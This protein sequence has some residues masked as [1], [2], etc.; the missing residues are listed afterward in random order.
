VSASNF[1]DLDE[2]V[3][4]GR[5]VNTYA[6]LDPRELMYYFEN[7]YNFPRKRLITDVRIRHP[8]F[9]RDQES[10]QNAVQSVLDERRW[11]DN[12][13]SLATD[14]AGGILD[15]G[16]QRDEEREI[17]GSDASCDGSLPPPATYRQPHTEYSPQ[18]DDGSSLEDSGYGH[19][20][21][22]WIDPYG[23]GRI[24]R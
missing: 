2:A 4:R 6:K 19:P 11:L 14:S 12:M 22:R 15:F 1:S 5:V 23:A 17:F 3:R 20:S 21:R 24:M 9:P 16:D 7:L 10:M 18:G 8:T 13:P